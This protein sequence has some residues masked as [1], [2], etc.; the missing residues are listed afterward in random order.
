MAPSHRAYNRRMDAIMFT[1]VALLIAA[2]IAFVLAIPTMMRRNFER[3]NKGR[4]MSSA[5]LGGMNEVWAPS[6]YEATIAWEAQTEAPAPAPNAGDK[7]RFGSL[8]EGVLRID[9]DAG[10]GVTPTSS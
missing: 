4:G 5:V 9:V 1:F 8:E 7:G 10:A 3:A 2:S 6:A